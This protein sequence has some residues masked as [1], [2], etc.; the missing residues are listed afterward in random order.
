MAPGLAFSGAGDDS[1]QRGRDRIS[2][3]DIMGDRL[4]Q[5]LSEDRRIPRGR[6]KPQRRRRLGVITDSFAG[7]TVQ[8]HR[9]DDNVTQDEEVLLHDVDERIG[10]GNAAVIGDGGG[11]HIHA[12][13]PYHQIYGGIV[14]DEGCRRPSPRAAIADGQI[15]GFDGDRDPAEEDVPDRAVEADGGV[16]VDGTGTGAAVDRHSLCPC[17]IQNGHV[18]RVAEIQLGVGRGD[19]PTAASAGKIKRMGDRAGGATH[20]DRPVVGVHSGHGLM[21]C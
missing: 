15:A 9:G 18:D 12:V 5:S 2:G 13:S 4:D 14:H 6:G 11:R 7:G 16:S 21:T 17:N 10:D 3:G 1:L 19:E 20:H 8:H